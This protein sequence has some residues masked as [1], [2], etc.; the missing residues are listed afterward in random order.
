MRVVACGESVG[1]AHLGLGPVLGTGAL[2]I[3]TDH[4][5]EQGLL[6]SRI[7]IDGAKGSWYAEHGMMNAVVGT[8]N[9]VL[10]RLVVPDLATDQR[11][12]RTNPGVYILPPSFPG[13]LGITAIIVDQH[14]A[15]RWSKKLDGSRESTVIRVVDASDVGFKIGVLSQ[16]AQV[17]STM[18][19][20]WNRVNS[21]NA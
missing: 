18:S 19:R 11:G 7:A 21:E 12:V 6:V 10:D 17:A 9:T 4:V 16:V 5:S 14:G 13:H 15:E 2:E 8:G 1:R 20:A 3:F